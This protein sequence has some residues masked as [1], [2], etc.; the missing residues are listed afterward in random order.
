MLQEFRP[1][2]LPGCKS[3]PAALRSSP[4]DDGPSA[5]FRFLAEACSTPNGAFCDQALRASGSGAIYFMSGETV[6]RFAGKEP[7][8][9]QRSERI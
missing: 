4:Y 2:L 8:N 6:L 1:I 9:L 3:R 7:Q 5:N